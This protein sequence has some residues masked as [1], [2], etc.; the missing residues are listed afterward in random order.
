MTKKF[1]IYKW[2]NLDTNEVF[3]IGKGCGNRVKTTTDRNELFK[4]YIKKHKCSSEVIKYF[5]TEEEA[6][7]EEHKL[8]VSLKKLGQCQCNLDNG[9]MGG[10]NFVWT[11]E[12]R[13]YKSKFNPMKNKEVVKRVVA[14]KQRAVIIENKYFNS[15]KE[16]T[17]YYK[18][19][20][21]EIIHW[22]KRGYDRNKK[23]CRYADEKQKA[24]EIKVTCSKKVIVDNIHFSSVKEAAKYLNSWS[25]TV[26]RAIKNNRK[27]K[28]HTVKY[29]NQQPSINL[30]DL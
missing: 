17:L 26:I 9:G 25:E 27:L 21:T 5:D 20:D 18:V 15:V 8:I 23:P 12:M 14:K 4:A 7:K 28:G 1:Y 30:K 13:A 22:C 16:A 10:T 6:F 3:Y 29:D 11:P 2:Y 19:F 24:F